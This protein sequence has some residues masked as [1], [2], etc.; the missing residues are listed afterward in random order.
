MDTNPARPSQ[1]LTELGELERLKSEFES[2]R[3]KI[4]AIS[5]ADSAANEDWLKDVHSAT[6]Y[7]VSFP[8]IHDSDFEIC[9]RLGMLPPSG[10]PDDEA[11]LR[12]LL[13]GVYLVDTMK[14]VR[15]IMHYPAS[16]GWSSYEILRA[17]DALFRADAQLACPVNWIARPPASFPRLFFPARP[18]DQPTDRPTDRP[19]DTRAGASRRRRRAATPSSSLTSRRPTRFATSRA[20]SGPSR[21]RPARTTSASR[22]TR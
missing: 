17:F 14:R 21:S 13:R 15:V 2:R 4:Y 10:Q 19:I 6:G 3:I 11:R 20:A 5:C 16:V 8:I 1:G 22:R 9:K 7:S 18:T 12:D